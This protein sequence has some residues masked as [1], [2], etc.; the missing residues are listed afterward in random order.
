MTIHLYAEHLVHIRAITI[1]ASLPTCTDEDT[2]A[3]LS[4]D[5][6]TLTLAH[7]GECASIKLPV[8]TTTTTTL[9]LPSA[10]ARNISFRIQLQHDYN[11]DQEQP[12][13]RPPLDHTE[14]N[15]N[16]IPW[17]APSLNPDVQIACRYCDTPVLPRANV[18]VWKD[19][20]SE[21]WAE[22]MDFWHCHRPHVPPN[23]D[24]S[25]SNKGYSAGSTLALQSGVGMVDP[26]DFVLAVED[27]ANLEVGYISPLFLFLLRVGHIKNRLFHITTM[28][29]SG[30]SCPR[31]NSAKKAEYETNP[32]GWFIEAPLFLRLAFHRHF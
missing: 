10:P 23:E 4:A 16:T 20:P 24:H 2:K 9:A 32:R 6:A 13:P 29:A 27:C 8:A 31:S 25:T 5:G 18:R 30:Y 14:Q 19:L 3:T 22:M 15:C 12:N 11:R 21:N 26:V 7:H 28:K 17:S 1:H